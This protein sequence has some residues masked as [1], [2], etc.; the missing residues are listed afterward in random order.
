MAL[1][2]NTPKC[3]YSSRQWRVIDSK[4]LRSRSITYCVGTLNLNRL[5]LISACNA[6]HVL[7][8]HLIYPIIIVGTLVSPGQEKPS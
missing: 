8:K 2:E 7:Y 6:L 1:F 3:S 4:G 5:R